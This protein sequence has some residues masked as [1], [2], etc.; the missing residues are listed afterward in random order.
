MINE[1]SFITNEKTTGMNGRSFIDGLFAEG[2]GKER[3]F[4]VQC[5]YLFPWTR[6]YDLLDYDSLY[7]SL[8][9]LWG[10][11]VQNGVKRFNRRL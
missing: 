2:T 10:L 8:L 5:L 7:L 4:P 9:S 3:D 6:E 11:R 1:W